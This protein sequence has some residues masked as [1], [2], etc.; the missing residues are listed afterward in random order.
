[1]C[2]FLFA[3]SPRAARLSRPL[4]AQAKKN[5]REG[6][7]SGKPPESGCGFTLRL[8]IDSRRITC[9]IICGVVGVVLPADV[10][11]WL[12]LPAIRRVPSHKTA[13][14]HAALPE[15]VQVITGCFK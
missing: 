3:G 8:R 6:G 1:M 15:L 2:K 14:S 4:P 9:R 5:R 11:G 13:I 10:F 12:R 7:L